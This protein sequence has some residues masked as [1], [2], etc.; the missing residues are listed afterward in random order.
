MPLRAIQV[1]TESQAIPARTMSPTHTYGWK[2]VTGRPIRLAD[3]LAAASNPPVQ[4]PARRLSL[5]AS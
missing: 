3:S 5:P 1:S 4:S 2:V